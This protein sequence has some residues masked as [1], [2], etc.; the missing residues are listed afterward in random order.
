MQEWLSQPYLGNPI[1]AYLWATGY[2][3]AGAIILAVLRRVVFG[4]LKRLAE[5]SA[6]PVDDFLVAS[7]EKTL[8]PLLYFGAFYLAVQNLSLSVPA[9]KTLST[10]GVVILTFLTVRFLSALIGFLLT[11]VWMKKGTNADRERNLKLLFPVLRTI[12]W[13]L[14]IVFLLDNMGFKISAVVAGL[15]IGG[16][17]VAMASQA[18][19]GDLFSYVAILLDKPFEIGDFVILEGGFMGTVEHIGIKTTRVR[20]LSG[21]QL[22][23]SNSD[24]TGSRVRNYKRMQERRVVFKLGLTY[25]TTPEKMERAVAIVKDIVAKQPDTRFDR[26]H[27]SE[28]GDFNLILETVYWVLSP[29]YNKYM[30]IQQDL[31]LA[32][33]RAFAKEG[34]EF[35]FPTQTLYVKKDSNL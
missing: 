4:R 22:V 8:M 15:G 2:F 10:L 32:L 21:E 34:I 35:A 26:A 30:D 7:L 11:E 9:Q 28:F 6:T 20:S 16:I 29:D 31:N 14:A 3:V 18:I 23:I 13:G 1:R 17:A 12:L 33:Q 25:G 5:K 19:L 24:L 27:F